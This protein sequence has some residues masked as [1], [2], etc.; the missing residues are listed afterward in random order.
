MLKLTTFID[1]PTFT[2]KIKQLWD[3]VTWCSRG[4]STH[5]PPNSQ[6]SK[7]DSFRWRSKVPPL[8][9]GKRPN[10]PESSGN[11]EPT[12]RRPVPVKYL[13]WHSQR[14]LHTL[15]MSLYHPELYRRT[16]GNAYTHNLWPNFLYKRNIDRDLR[17]IPLLREPN[18]VGRWF[19]KP[20]RSFFLELQ[21]FSLSSIIFCHFYESCSFILNKIRVS[22]PPVMSPLNRSPRDLPSIG[23]QIYPTL[24]STVEKFT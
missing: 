5:S 1:L 18:I 19:W 7:H 16:N 9:V 17:R 3:V 21:S 23:S 22:L 11:T 6:V 14:T 12:I 20:Y 24:T 15:S 2:P 10:N 4:S 8:V 13:V